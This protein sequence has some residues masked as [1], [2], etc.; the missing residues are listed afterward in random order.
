V[1]SARP[2]NAIDET[3]RETVL[4]SIK[5]TRGN[6]RRMARELRMPYRTMHYTLTRF[7]LREDLERVRRIRLVRS[8]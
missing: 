6:V 3:L 8:R 7:A 2:L 5:R 1:N 4:A